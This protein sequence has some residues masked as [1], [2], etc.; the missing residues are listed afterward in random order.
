MKLIYIN[1][2][3]NNLPVQ[4]GSLIGT[5]VLQTSLRNITFILIIL[6]ISLRFLFESKVSKMKNSD[7]YNPMYREIEEAVAFIAAY[8]Y[9][10][11]PRYQVNRFAVKL[12][13]TLLK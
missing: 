10:K 12:A 11:L 3:I 5:P 9:Y 7:H 4:V 1:Q 2:F 8:F 13:N 6:E